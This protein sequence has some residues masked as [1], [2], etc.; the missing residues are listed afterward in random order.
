M[1]KYFFNLVNEELRPDIL[2]AWN[3]QFDIVYLLN[4]ISLLSKEPFEEGVKQHDSMLRFNETARHLAVPKEFIANNQSYVF[5]YRDTMNP[6]PA[7]SGSYLKISS[8]TIYVDQMLIYAQLRKGALKSSYSLNNIALDE[9]ND[10][11]RPLPEG[12]DMGNFP[13]RAYRDFVKYN[14]HDVILLKKIRRQT[15]RYRVGV[16]DIPAEWN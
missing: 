5:F 8:Y 2:G 3:I 14:V 10:T 6:E 11:K 1:I 7:K 12:V 13:H 16:D 9:L 4:R 15:K